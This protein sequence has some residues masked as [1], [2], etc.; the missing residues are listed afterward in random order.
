MTL[1]PVTER[2]FPC[3]VEP[4]AG[5]LTVKISTF[6]TRMNGQN[7]CQGSITG[8]YSH[9]DLWTYVKNTLAHTGYD[10]PTGIRFDIPGRSST[11][12]SLPWRLPS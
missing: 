8:E 10:Q 6:G 9:A 4:F 5:K 3:R 1:S 12:L 2:T 11:Y 7:G